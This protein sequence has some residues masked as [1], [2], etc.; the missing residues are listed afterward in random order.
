MLVGFADDTGRRGLV[1]IR[2]FLPHLLLARAP[3]VADDIVVRVFGDLESI[4]HADLAATL[5][6][7]VANSFDRGATAAELIVHRNTCTKTCSVWP[8]G[9]IRSSRKRADPTTSTIYKDERCMN[10]L[11]GTPRR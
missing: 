1:S 11:N 10:C 5:R 3:E 4:E 2:D 8:S 7:L 9:G 6:C